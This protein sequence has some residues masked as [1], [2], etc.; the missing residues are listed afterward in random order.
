M[1]QI[2]SFADNV[3][4]NTG[5]YN[6]LKFKNGEIVIQYAGKTRRDESQLTA[7]ETAKYVAKL[8]K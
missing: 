4:N 7:E 5:Y 8:L 6:V 1:E 2:I 3:V